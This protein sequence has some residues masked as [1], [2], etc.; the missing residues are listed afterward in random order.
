MKAI[1]DFSFDW[2]LLILVAVVLLS[3][4]NPNSSMHKDYF[5]RFG[6]QLSILENSEISKIFGRCVTDSGNNLRSV[7]E[8][9]LC[10]DQVISQQRLDFVLFSIETYYSIDYTELGELRQ[11][12][13]GRTLGVLGNVVLL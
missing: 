10:W 4:K 8:T 1:G 9:R 13:V 7:Q 12:Q 3:Y 2:R 11:K 5:F 6:Y